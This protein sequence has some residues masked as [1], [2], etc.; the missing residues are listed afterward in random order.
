MDATLVFFIAPFFALYIT[1]VLWMWDG[2]AKRA[3]PYGPALA[4]AAFFLIFAEPA[5]E[6]GLGQIWRLDG[7]VVLP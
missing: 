5:V 2:A 3:M 4:A 1:L 6:W 7:P